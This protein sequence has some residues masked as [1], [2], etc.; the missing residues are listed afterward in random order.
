MNVLIVGKN[1]IN[2]VIADRLEARGYTALTIED[3]GLV[4]GL[5]GESGSFTLR[6]GAGAGI[7]GPDTGGTGETDAVA[8]LVSEPAGKALPDID[9]G[10]PVYLFDTDAIRKIADRRAR[11]PVVFVLDYFNES[12]L[13]S[14]VRTL[15]VSRALALKKRNVVCLFRFMRSAGLRHE[16]LYR[17]ARNA[18]VTFIKYE[19]LDLRYDDAK[20]VFRI[21]VSD[22]IHQ[23]DISTKHVVTDSGYGAGDSLQILAGKLR[24]KVNPAGY[25]NEDRYMLNPTLTSR[26]GVYY[27]G[28]DVRA[29]KF[30]ESLRYTL[31][32]IE[33]D[34]GCPAGETPAGGAV[35]GSP[36]GGAAAEDP[37]K[38]V[39]VVDGEKCV[40]CYTC[41]RACPHGAMEPE[42]DKRAMKNLRAACE[43]CG[44]CAAVCPA[45]A[46]TLRQDDFA[47]GEAEGKRGRVKLYCCENSGDIALREVLP[48]MGDLA[49]R[50]DMETVPC[51]GRIGFE[52]LSGA[53]RFYGRTVAL[54]CMDDA[55]K[56]F[57]G[58][59]RACK[60]ADRL[61]GM[62]EDAGVDK[63]KVGYIQTSHA[64]ARVL[65]DKLTDML[66]DLVT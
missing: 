38:N 60:Q 50:I 59:K 33:A 31:S 11:T 42:E 61:S 5:L 40:F 27:F 56:H 22:G 15:E 34:V 21:A 62:L 46:I 36:A 32:A 64:M 29:D 30:D 37:D 35:T 39:A 2:K 47:P 4:R 16:T 13:A 54:V 43:A 53:L 65:R 49:S 1:E 57:D 8:V 9:G 26:K 28:G 55:C 52:Q 66:Q 7:G 14:T 19:T 23:V 45:N 12:P 20:D 63:G 51:G 58:N 17:A 25:V 18:G 6:L 24:L 3:V 44:I 10:R 48:M 41:Y